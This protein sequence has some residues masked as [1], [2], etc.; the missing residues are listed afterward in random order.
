MNFAL[1][2]NGQI[3]DKLGLE[4]PISD[5][6]VSLKLY[7]GKILCEDLSMCWKGKCLEMMLNVL[8]GSA[9]VD[10]ANGLIQRGN[11]SLWAKGATR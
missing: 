5:Y 8:Q 9:L 3:G 2:K 4:E 7:N 11:K 6:P 1:C 10:V